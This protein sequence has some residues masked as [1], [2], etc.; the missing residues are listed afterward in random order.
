MCEDSKPVSSRQKTTET[1]LNNPGFTVGR[2]ADVEVGGGGGG[3]L[4]F[5]AEASVFLHDSKL[6]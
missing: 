6:K 2:K 3:A 5:N 1:P 4:I